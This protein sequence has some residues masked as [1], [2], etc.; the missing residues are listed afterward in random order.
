M[1]NKKITILFLAVFATF[2][3]G[4]QTLLTKKEAI[5][6]AL[7]N[8]YGIKIAYNNVA[9]AKNNSSIYNSRFLPTVSA[10]TGTNYS[11]SNQSITSQTGNVTAIDG[12]VTKSYNAALNVNYTLF[13]GLG[14]KYNYQQ[15]K[16]TYNLSKLQAK[17]TIENTYLQLFT[18]Y[19]EIGRLSENT[20]SLQQALTI[21]KQRLKRAEY[22]FEYGQ[23]T[24]IELLNAQVDVNNDSISLMNSKQL[25]FN[26]KRSLNI[27]LGTTNAENFDV[28]TTVTFNK[29]LNVTELLVLAKANN[30][31]L[32]QQ[33]K[34]IAISE[35]NIKIN[36][37][38]FL[39]T[40][41]LTSSYGWNKNL[42]PATSF[43]AQSQ[44]NGI[45]AGL[46]LSWNLFDGG[47]TKTRVANSKI[48]LETQKISQQ[49]Q[50]ETISN[51][52]KNTWGSYQNSLFI[53]KAQEQ[54]ILTSQNNFNR[55]EEKYKLGQVTSI[56]FR[57]AQI[58]LINTKTAL[59]NAK[60]DAKLIELQLLQLSGQLINSD[61]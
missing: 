1:K 16:E 42:N 58:N 41:S 10:T 24:K 56:E 7:E 53:L 59:N 13:D 32:K 39:P 23:S 51:N 28:E 14:R 36:K 34:N 9:V 18:V 50:E 19:F 22:Q 61:I 44:S 31:L 33:K 37:A 5:K 25:F 26:S 60:F 12:A 6:I 38:N 21:S 2:Q 4:A 48:A 30:T 46:N 40:L 17:E 52:L 35:F 49:Q 43:F 29:L 57:Q 11:N 45:N 15:L 55:T 27:V 3:L 8:N 54:N 47:N 20:K